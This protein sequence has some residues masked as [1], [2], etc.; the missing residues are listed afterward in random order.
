MALFGGQ[1]IEI[2]GDIVRYRLFL[3]S[4]RTMSIINREV[5]K[6][7]TKSSRFL[8]R[9]IKEAIRAKRFTENSP[10]TIALAKGVAT[11]SKSRNLIRALGFKKRG[12]FESEVGIVEDTQTTGGVSGDKRSMQKVATLLHKGYTITVT[13][14]MRKAIMAELRKKAELSGSATK[15]KKAI[16]QIGLLKGKGAKFFKVPPRKFLTNTFKNTA[17]QQKVRN[18]WSEAVE[19][20]FVLSGVKP[21][22]AKNR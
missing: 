21:S 20:A 7:T 3:D 1:G 9:K 18:N 13:K 8:I 2:T 15:A 11:L 17:V 5:G 22:D 10:L 12:Q 16:R 14:R 6:A 19:R 4:G